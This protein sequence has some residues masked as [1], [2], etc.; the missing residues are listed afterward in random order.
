[1]PWND[2]HHGGSLTALGADCNHRFCGPGV[3]FYVG[4]GLLNQTE[5]MEPGIVVQTGKNVLKGRV[6]FNTPAAVYTGPFFEIPASHRLTITVP[7]EVPAGPVPLTFTP[8]VP[9]RKPLSRHFGRLKN[10][11]AFAGAAMEIQRRMRV[12]W[13]D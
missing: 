10:S 2:H 4:Q 13:D 11:K 5:T 3:F 12:E 1:L 9:D 6:I 7:R 8:T